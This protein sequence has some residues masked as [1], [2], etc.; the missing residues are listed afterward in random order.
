VNISKLA[1]FFAASIFLSGVFCITVKADSAVFLDGGPGAPVV[2]KIVGFPANNGT[3]IFAFDQG[4]LTIKLA[5]PTGE[6]TGFS[7]GF[8]SISHITISHKSLG[9]SS[10]MSEI[11]P[12]G[13]A[14]AEE[15][16]VLFRRTITFTLYDF[17]GN[18][19]IHFNKS[20]G[21]TEKP[22]GC[23]GCSGGATLMPEPATLLLLGSGLVGVSGL[24]RRQF[25]KKH[26]V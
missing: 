22:V 25:K 14:R 24:V 5:N 1:T 11:S 21:R 13:L 9:R 8:D 2:Y 16:G 17:S 12:A 7:F 18:V 3:A 10:A 4:V 15:L 23:L 19:M 20:N 26:Q 6:T